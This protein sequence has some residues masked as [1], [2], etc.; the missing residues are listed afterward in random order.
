MKIRLILQSSENGEE[1]HVIFTE[2]F[3]QPVSQFLYSNCTVDFDGIIIADL[4]SGF[5]R[6]YDLKRC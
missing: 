5:P 2:E 4:P 3:D 1:E 6:E